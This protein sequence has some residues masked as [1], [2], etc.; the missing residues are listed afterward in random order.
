MRRHRYRRCGPLSA[1][2]GGSPPPRRPVRIAAW[3][4]SMANA[5]KQ[6]G[7]RGEREAVEVLTCLAPDLLVDKPQRKLGAGRKED[8]GDLVV[9]PDVTIQVKTYGK[10]ETILREA[11]VG[12]EAQRVRA[13]STFALGMAPI[14]RARR[15]SVRWLAAVLSWPGGDP[16]DLDLV[17]VGMVGRAVTHL[18][19]EDLGVRRDRRIVAVER[20]GLPRL[21]IATIDAWMAAWRVA[22]D[23]RLQ[24]SLLEPGW[25]DDDAAVAHLAGSQHAQDVRSSVGTAN[26]S[27]TAGDEPGPA[28]HQLPRL[29]PAS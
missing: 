24:L 6:K 17:H 19:R 16:D 28:P 7:D 14:P 15:G 27:T 12:A 11:A 26:R 1:S 25:E 5:S 23:G 18:R 2:S 22:R 13:G 8:T 20:A 9:L 21:Y 29:W 4:C 3:S 10:V